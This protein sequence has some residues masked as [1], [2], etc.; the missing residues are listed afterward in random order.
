MSSEPETVADL[1]RSQGQMS[2]VEPTTNTLIGAFEAEHDLQRL[3]SSSGYSYWLAERLGVALKTVQRWE[4]GH[5]AI[6]EGV[7]QEL[8]IIATAMGELAARPCAEQ[9]L[10]TPD[11]VMMIPRAGTHL[12]F[13]RIV[14]PRPR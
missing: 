6:P 11:G 7:A 5:R 10:A 3:S 13:P 1:L 12:G 14:V 4:N 9:L 8:D 2:F